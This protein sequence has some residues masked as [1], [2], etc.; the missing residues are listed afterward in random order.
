MEDRIII[1][2]TTLRDGEQS[3]GCSMNVDEKVRMARQLERLC[4]DVIEAGFPVASTGDFESVRSIAGIVEQCVVAAL[5]RAVPGDIDR[6]WEAVGQARHPRLHTFIATS[7]IH[8]FHKLKK[9][10]PQ[11][12]EDAVRAVSHAKALC[13]DVEF[14]CEDASRSDIVFLCEILEAAID[15]GANVVNLPDTVGYSV[16]GEYGAMFKSIRERVPNIGRAILSTHCHND[17]GL[18]V[19]NSLAAI[20]HGARQVE[21]TVNG[22]GERAGNAALEEIVLAI[23]TRRERLGVTTGVNPEE[24]YRSSKLLTS[25]T[26]MMVQRN[27]AIVGANAFAHEAGIH[28]DGMLKSAITYEIMTPQSVGIKH[29]T[30]V[31]GKHSGRHALKQ[32]YA[33]L[34]YDLSPEE[35]ERAYAEFCTIADQKKEIFDE[36]LVAILE[37]TTSDTEQDY[38]LLGL[39]VSSGTGVRPTATVE[40]RLGEERFVDS[41]TG[42]GPV[43]AAYRAIE[44]I[45]GVAGKLTE[46]SLKSVSLGHDAIGE[47]FVRIELEGLHFNGRAASTDIILGSAKAYLEAMNRALGARRRKEERAK[48]PLARATASA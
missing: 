30:L 46:Y 7:D 23:K 43:D 33:E 38:Q 15:A 16:P 20:E 27:K 42:D 32:R 36:E 18:A 13:Q 9:T 28:Q 39:H 14:S 6:A 1:F 40:L 8:L 5:C 41:A 24:I 29:S 35:L 26:G 2:D 4:V 25:L 19:A 10:R 45:T 34:G 44:R 17:L 11:V 3:P 12:L 37:G 48:E 22:I 21:C 47:A 31:L